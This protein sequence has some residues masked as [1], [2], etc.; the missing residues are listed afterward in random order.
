VVVAGTQSRFDFEWVRFLGAEMVEAAEGRC[1]MRLQPKGVHLNHNGNVNA[2]ILYGLA[3]VAG[4]GA[5]T[6]G[7]MDLLA[8]AYVVVKRATIEYLAPAHDTVTAAG[9][10]EASAFTAARADVAAG[11]PVDVA[12]DVEITDAT[13]RITTRVNLTMSVRPKRTA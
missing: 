10:V 3:E 7:M 12:A 2:P 6:T 11:I 4:A 5:V 9:T 13:G 8:T 1:V